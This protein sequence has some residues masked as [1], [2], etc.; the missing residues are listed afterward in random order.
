MK[1][2]LVGMFFGTVCVSIYAQN[3]KPAM[4]PTNME[5]SCKSYPF[6]PNPPCFQFCVMDLSKKSLA[7]LA[8]VKNL[9]VGVSDLIRVLSESKNRS[10]I[11]FDSITKESDL[12]REALKSQKANKKLEKD[13]ATKKR[14]DDVRIDPFRGDLVQ[15]SKGL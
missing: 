8:Q 12:K 2:M 6:K 1:K 11:D 10:A 3:A 14:K 9:D 13:V 7:E 4:K 15:K 5:C